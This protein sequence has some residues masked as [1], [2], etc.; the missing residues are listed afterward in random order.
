MC[1]AVRCDKCGKAT[2]SGCGQHIEEALAPFGEDQR[3]K[4]D[5]DLSSWVPGQK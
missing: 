3:C 2:W 4:C 5:A 1:S